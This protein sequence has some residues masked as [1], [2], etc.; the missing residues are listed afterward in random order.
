MSTRLFQETLNQVKINS[1]RIIGIVDK[2]GIIVACTDEVMVGQVIAADIADRLSECD[3]CILNSNFYKTIGSVL[4]YEYVL[5]VSGTDEVAETLSSVLSVTFKTLIDGT[6]DKNDKYNFIR[7]VMLGN[8]YPNDVY[9]KARDAHFTDE[10]NHVVLYLHLLDSADEILV[11]DI[12]QSLFPDK[13]KDY[14]ISITTSDIALVKEVRQNT[15]F[16]D[17]E[18]LA[19]SIIDTLN[20]EFYVKATIGIGSIISNISDLSRSFREARVSTEIGRIFDPSK[21]ILIYNNLG[22]GKLIY[23]LPTSLCKEYVDDVFVR[24]AI[25]SLDPEILLT[26]REF[27]ENSLN[28]SETSRKLFIHRN[29]LVYRLEKV[30]RITGLDLKEFDQAIVFEIALMIHQYLKSNPSKY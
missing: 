21:S 3:S 19:H 29:T 8:Y 26:I 17:L 10:A 2:S 22:I 30:R 5:F 16:R 18:K 6:E 4:R 24:G 7:N 11:F 14:V 23:N 12:I 20:S 25:E 1:D 9:L 15:D 27:F 13:S 28:V